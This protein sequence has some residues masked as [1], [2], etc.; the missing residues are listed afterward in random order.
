MNQKCRLR[1]VRQDF[2]VIFRH[3]YPGDHDEH[4]AVLLAGTSYS[5]GQLTLHVREVHLAEEGT[6]YVEGK[7]G[8]RA[9]S[10][11]F[12][13]RLIT[14]AR[15]ERLAYLAVHNHGSDREVGFSSI[16]YDSHERGYPALL[17]IARGMPVGALVFGHRSIEA[18]VWL[19][20]HTRFSLDEAI[21]VGNTIQSLTPSFKREASDAAGHYD[22][23][24]RMFGNAGQRRLGK[25]R[26]G[27]IGLGGIGSIVAEYLARLGVGEFYLVDDDRVEESN[28]SRVVGASAADAVKGTPKIEVARRLILKANSRASVKK[29]RKDVAQESAAKE[30]ASCDYL[31]LA[32]DSMRARLVFNA[33]VHQYLIPGVQLGSKVRSDKVGALVEVMSANRPVRPGH[34]C[35]WCNQLIDPNQ[36][37][38]E[39]KTD[40]ERKAQAYGVGEPNPSVISLN[41]VSAAHAVNDF[42]L[43]YLGLRAERET[44]YYEEFHFLTDKRNLVQPRQDRECSECSHGGLRYGRGDCVALPCAED[45]RVVRQ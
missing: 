14:R 11:S 35:L 40:E 25:C 43:D 44:L 22:R 9:L 41:A 7:I 39:A 16:D 13:H 24:V 45:K 21:V 34:G 29:I 19:P 2:D 36:L 3:L 32:A 5:K 15:D 38:V 37:A 26:V 31:F 30:L 23:Q 28:L 18:D 12:I 27:I 20:D 17:Q 4:G 10:P 1:I 33:L 8:Y 6:D 42:L